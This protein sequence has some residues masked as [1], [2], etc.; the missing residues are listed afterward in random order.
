MYLTIFKRIFSL[1]DQLTIGTPP[2]IDSLSISVSDGTSLFISWH[3]TVPH[4]SYTLTLNVSN[5][6]I[7]VTDYT[8]YKATAYV[9]GLNAV[10]LFLL[11]QST[12]APSCNTSDMKSNSAYVLPG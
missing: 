12:I 6:A 10:T 7:D 8:E 11:V 2:S 1:H 9:C 4:D 5:T 3:I